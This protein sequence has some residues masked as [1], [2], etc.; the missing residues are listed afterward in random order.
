M[1]KE[2]FKMPTDK[3]IVDFAILFN[4]G[5]L[6]EDRLTDMVALNMMI[7]ERLYENGDVMIPAKR[8]L[9]DEPQ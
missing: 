9:K 3:Q 8:E 4:D 6:D 2:R 5:Y 1:S 7:L